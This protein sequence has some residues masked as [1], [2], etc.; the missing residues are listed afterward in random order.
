MSESGRSVG[1]PTAFKPEF[2]EEMISLMATG[3]SLTAAAAALGFTRQSIYDWEAA[4]PDFAEAMKL[5]R[6][7]RTLKLEQDLLTLENGPQVTARIFALKN[8]DPTEWREKTVQELTG[9]DGGPIETRSAHS[10][11]DDDL[12]RIAASSRG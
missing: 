3:L 11:T 9:K 10:M 5:A 4:H 2:A 6:G 8:A 12:A 7:K 1:R